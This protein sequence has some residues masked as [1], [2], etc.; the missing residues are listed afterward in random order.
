[1]P[2]YDFRCNQC[3]HVFTV[4]ATFKEKEAGLQLECPVCHAQATRQVI[5]AGLLIGLAAGDA[6]SAPACGP[7]AG[8][9]CCG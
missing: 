6:R 3:D 2:F 1:M 5:T 7:L 4:R 8:P 9:G